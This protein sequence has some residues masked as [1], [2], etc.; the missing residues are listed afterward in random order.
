[1]HRFGPYKLFRQLNALGHWERWIALHERDDTDH[2][3]YR[4]ARSLDAFE[5]RR[6]LQ[7]VSKVSRPKHPH[8]LPINAYSFDETDRLC[9]VSPYTGNQEGLVPIKHLLARRSGRLE[10]PEVAR[11]VEHL[12][13]GIACARSHGVWVDEIDPDRVLIDR[14]GSV[15]Y[16][17]YG[18]VNPRLCDPIAG[19]VS[20]EIRAIA[21]IAAWLLTGVEPSIAP[22]SVTKVAGRQA[23]AWDAWISA[24]IDPLGGFERIDDAIAS[25]PS[26]DG[27]TPLP[28]SKPDVRVSAPL[29]AVMRRF[30]R[31]TNGRSVLP[32]ETPTA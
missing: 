24:A 16:E 26:R 17:L 18:I 11:C 29:N 6:M 12:L 9:L 10:V 20:D 13:E 3:V 14:R 8:L 15:I 32:N 30:R 27:V 23:K 22:V 28:Q 7:I 25:M 4:H 2:V 21:Q 19:P 31:D 1:L 5:R